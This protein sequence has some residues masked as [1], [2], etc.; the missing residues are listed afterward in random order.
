L[1]IEEFTR[2][3]VVRFDDL[4]PEKGAPA[5]AEPE[6]FERERLM[7]LGRGGEGEQ[8]GARPTLDAGIN[9][10]YV[11]CDPGKGFSFHQHPGWEIFVPL[12]GRWRISRDDGA[13]PLEIGPWDA[14]TAPGDSFHGAQNIGDARAVMMSVSP[15]SD[16]AS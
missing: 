2:R 1:D 16:T 10:A 13:A 8:G 9:L 14:V 15:G 5:D 12:S 4:A 11:R 3:Y 7:V 6:R